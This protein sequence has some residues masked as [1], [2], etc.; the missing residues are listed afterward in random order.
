MVVGRGKSVRISVRLPET[1]YLQPQALAADNDVSTLW[2]ICQAV[3]RF[4]WENKGQTELPLRLG[5]G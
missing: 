5:K 2:I 4:L 3:I 1:H